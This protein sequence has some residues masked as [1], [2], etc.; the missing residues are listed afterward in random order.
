MINLIEPV[1]PRL[2]PPLE[3]GICQYYYIDASANIFSTLTNNYLTP[4][5]TEN[6]Y[7]Q[8]H[9]KTETGYVCRKLHR[10]MMMTFCYF[11]GCENFQVNH[12]DGKKT[13]NKLYNLEWSTPKENTHHA[14][15]NNLRVSFEGETNPNAKITEY[16]AK[17]IIEMLLQNN[18]DQYISENLNI[19]IG[20]IQCIARGNTWTYLTDT[21]ISDLR[22]TRCG[23]K[24]TEEQYHG[25]CKYFQD[26]IDKYPKKKGSIKDMV[27]DALHS[28]NS[29]VDDSH[30]RIARRLYYKYDR[31]DI[32]SL[33][34]Y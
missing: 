7:L 15:N 27:I 33:Y 12:K 24:L 11:T 31:D 8:V 2:I 14:I 13:N 1:E 20:I 4:Q 32:T 26:N 23:Y 29:I 21:V 6:G 25:I 30:I 3:D 18:S 22:K 17:Q 5:F 19:P 9:L 34:K 28:V 10:L 16:Q